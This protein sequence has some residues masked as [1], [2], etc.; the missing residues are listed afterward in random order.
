M[1]QMETRMEKSFSILV[2]DDENSIR[3]FLETFLVSEG[4]IVAKAAS[5]EE[6]LE[7]LKTKIFNLVISDVKMPG[8]SGVALLKKIMEMKLGCDVIIMSG[9]GTHKMSITAIRAGA[10]DFLNKPFDLDDMLARVKKIEE[11]QCREEKMRKL[12]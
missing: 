4:F 2:V 11:K 3:D 8:M 10:H 1:L 12:I 5:A 6:A 9:E 7:I